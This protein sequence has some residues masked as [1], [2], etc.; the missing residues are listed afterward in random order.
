[1]EKD[2]NDHVRELEDVSSL[3]KKEDAGF[4]PQND[5]HCVRTPMVE[6]EPIPEGYWDRHSSINL[7]A[8]NKWFMGGAD[9]DLEI[10][11]KF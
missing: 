10:K 2:K 7:K 4:G 5:L 3:E 11:T 9:Q 6:P 8:V 1:M